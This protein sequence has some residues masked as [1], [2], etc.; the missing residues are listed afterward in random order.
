[1]T[2]LIRITTVAYS[3]GGLL[4][5]QLKFMSEHFEVIG[6]S[7]SEDGYLKRVISK[8]EG[9]RVI[10]L[11]MTRRITLFKDFSA[12]WKLFWI[13]KREKPF[14][15]HTHTPKAGTVGMFA[16]FLAGVPNRLHTIAG[17]PLMEATGPKRRLLDLVEKLTYKC[18]TKIYP[19]S[20]GLE[21][22]I[23]DGNYTVPNKL[24]V[25]GNGSS[26]GIDTT[27]FDPALV[28]EDKILEIR[29]TYSIRPEHFVFIFVGRL[30]RDKGINELVSAFDTLSKKYPHIKLLLVG[31]YE[32][33]LDP[34]DAKTHKI[35][36]S[37]KNIITTGTQDDVR[38]Y[39]KLSDL[40]TFPSYREGF[41]NVVMEAGAMGLPAI[42]SDINGCN[43]I[44]INGENG[45]I[46]PP[47]SEPAL[48][49]KMEEL[50]S[51]PE[52]LK[53]LAANTRPMIKERFERKF[54]WEALLKEYKSLEES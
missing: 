39:L 36:A 18:A 12:F 38:P 22:F 15:V 11:E 50:M 31:R 8:K 13:F 54:V 51:A 25:I 35:I 2:K 20:Y 46:V 6:I 40:L 3:L 45:F 14:I 19:N 47:K 28:T 4:K 37:N 34:L 41:P 43:E 9:I 5:G 32:M 1:M 30:V 24:K 52:T 42:V 27:I 16:A 26:N 33:E 53:V 7:S 17:M 49:E 44:I 29:K 10:P 48:L 23:I 21:Q